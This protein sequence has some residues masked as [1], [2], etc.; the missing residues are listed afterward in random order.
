MKKLLSKLFRPLIIAG[1]LLLIFEEWLWEALSGLVGRLAHLVGL[2]R[3]EAWIGRLPPY[4]ALAF[5]LL[6]SIVV[7]PAK[8]VGLSLLAHGQVIASLSVFGGAKLAGTA[9]VAR[10]FKLTKP[11]LLQLVW[12]SALHRFMTGWLVRAH[13]W[14][15]AL[16]AVVAT[17][18]AVRRVR[19][20]M[21]RRRRSMFGRKVAAVR[22][23]LKR[24]STTDA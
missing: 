4:W 12:F 10:I 15:D 8:L 17:R 21:A 19:E 2:D 22:S 20:R 9:L 23:A 18:A 7:L 16:P 5:F 6:P 11:Q 13:A 14:F 1:A 24:S 3:V